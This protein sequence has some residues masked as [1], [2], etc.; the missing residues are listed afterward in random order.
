MA[1]IDDLANLV[2]PFRWV[3][4]D[5]MPSPSRIEIEDSSFSESHLIRLMHLADD[6]VTLTNFVISDTSFG[7]EVI[8]ILASRKN[9]EM[10]SLSGNR[11]TQ[12]GIDRLQKAL[13]NCSVFGP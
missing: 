8:D 1:A 4:F 11:F 2:E 13:P 6:V 9:A 12:E 5:C 3:R 7:D 10:F